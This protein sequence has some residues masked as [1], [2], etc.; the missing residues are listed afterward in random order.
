MARNKCKEHLVNTATELFARNGFH[1]TG[2]DTVTK[3]ADVARMSLYNNFA[4]KD[5]LID[6]VLDKQ[7]ELTEAWLQSI[8]DGPGDAQS[9]FNAMFD[10]LGTR[11]NSETYFGCPFINAAAEFSCP[12]HPIHKTAKRHKERMAGVL[13]ELLEQMNVT[14]PAS[15][16]AQ[17]MLVL[18]GAAVRAQVL[19][20]AEAHEIA[21]SA[22]NAIVSAAVKPIK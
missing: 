11:W 14:D 3:E 10:D 18:D 16:A 4:S 19:R 22:A 1:A 21:R 12:E 7:H 13:K 20:D 5:D 9:R 2:I 6:A 15:T 8:V 17:L